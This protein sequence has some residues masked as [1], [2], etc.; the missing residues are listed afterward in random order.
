[1][2]WFKAAAERA[3][4]ERFLVFGEPDLRPEDE[5]E[6]LDC[7]RSRWIGQG[8]RVERFEEEFRRYQGA[9]HAVAVSS[10]TAV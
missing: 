6:V 10:C 8:P 5:R 4:R 3:P 9:E 2:S 1:M 7:L